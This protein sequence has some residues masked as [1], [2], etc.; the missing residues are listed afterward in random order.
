MLARDVMGLLR[1]WM[2]CCPESGVR[3]E[4][5]CVQ[6]EPVLCMWGAGQPDHAADGGDQCRAARLSTTVTGLFY[7]CLAVGNR[8]V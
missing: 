3:I 4:Q 5:C 6:T 8:V 2:R 1:D 7:V